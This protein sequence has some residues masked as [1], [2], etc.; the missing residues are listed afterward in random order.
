M[1]KADV[2]SPILETYS[3]KLSRSWAMI[4]YSRTVTSVWK[5]PNCS[6]VRGEVQSV[7][8][9]Q[10]TALPLLPATFS[11]LGPRSDSSVC[12]FPVYPH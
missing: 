6:S 3:T 7:D 11:S 4:V 9:P 10:G 2:Y 12:V 8:T 1:N 5:Q